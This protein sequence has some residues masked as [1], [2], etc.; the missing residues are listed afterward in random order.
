MISSTDLLN[1]PITALNLLAHS[2]N[3]VTDDKLDYD[4]FITQLKKRVTEDPSKWD[5]C[6]I[7]NFYIIKEA[8]L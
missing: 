5:S 3:I 8:D 6:L 7:S 4:A 1:L 2:K